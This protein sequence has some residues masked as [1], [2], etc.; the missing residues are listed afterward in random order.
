MIS[1]QTV[2]KFIFL[3]ITEPLPVCVDRT[4][5]ASPEP[6]SL[7]RQ[8]RPLSARRHSPPQPDGPPPEPPDDCGRA[9]SEQPPDGPSPDAERD[10]DPSAPHHPQPI[11]Y[12]AG[13]VTQHGHAWKQQRVVNHIQWLVGK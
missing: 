12:P 4:T 5:L 2:R 7:F 6:S 8:S 13:R 9:A 1:L 11:L 3:L 10:Q